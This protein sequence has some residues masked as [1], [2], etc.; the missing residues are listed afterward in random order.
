M[1]LLDQ[2]SSKRVLEPEGAISA[3]LAD[4]A[5]KKAK[6]VLE[7]EGAESAESSGFTEARGGAFPT[8]PC[9]WRSGPQDED[10]CGLSPAVALPA[11]GSQAD[12]PGWQAD[13]PARQP[14]G[15]ARVDEIMGIAASAED[16]AELGA[17]LR[18]ALQE[19]AGHL[20]WHRAILVL[21]L[22]RDC[23]S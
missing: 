2:P 11:G 6:R 7:P 14:R 8:V 3:E 13:I 22:D 5:E 4:G 21:D 17:V 23:S 9:S 15:E 19:P 18:N 1:A 12:I 20:A 16:F 10:F